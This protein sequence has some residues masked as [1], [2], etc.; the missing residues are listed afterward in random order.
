LSMKMQGRVNTIFIIE[1]V[2]S[3]ASKMKKV[4]Y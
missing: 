4:E 3:I 2:R 1:D